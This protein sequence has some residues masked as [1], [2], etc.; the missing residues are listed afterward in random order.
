MTKNWNNT[1]YRDEDYQNRHPDIIYNLYRFYK[2]ADGTYT[3]PEAVRYEVLSNG[4]A[5]V[6]FKDLCIYAPD[7]TLCYYYVQ[8][9]IPNGYKEAD[10]TLDFS[11][12]SITA[13]TESGLP[14]TG[15]GSSEIFTFNGTVQADGTVSDASAKGTITN[16][17][18]KPGD[19]FLWVRRPGM[20]RI[21][22]LAHGRCK[23]RSV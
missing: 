7:G 8:E 15:D 1:I 11:D 5:S 4:D 13:V 20:T 23:F 9:Q 16:S 12:G 17:Y 19:V 6:T 18:E 3:R 14:K 10:I 22:L 2:N 21:M